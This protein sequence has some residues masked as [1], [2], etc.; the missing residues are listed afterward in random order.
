MASRRDALGVSFD[1]PVVSLRSTTGYR[2][3]SRWDHSDFAVTDH[4]GDVGKM[5][6]MLKNAEKIIDDLMLTRY[7]CYFPV[8]N[9]CNDAGGIPS[10]SRWLSEATPP[11]LNSPESRTP[12]GVPANAHASGRFFEHHFVGVNKMVL[13]GHPKRP[14]GTNVGVR[15]FETRIAENVVELL[16]V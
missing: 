13:A 11:D 4:F 6:Q 8:Y 1:D 5:I 2:L 9:G 10:C 14:V 3:R 15:E 16:K 12:A 7:T